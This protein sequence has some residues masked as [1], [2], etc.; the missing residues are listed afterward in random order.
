MHDN[1]NNQTPEEKNAQHEAQA[2]KEFAEIAASASTDGKSIADVEHLRMVEYIHSQLKH[3]QQIDDCHIQA[4]LTY[5]GKFIV[6]TFHRDIED[7]IEDTWK[8]LIE[9][10][11]FVLVENADDTTL[12]G[13]QCMGIE[14]GMF[15]DYGDDEE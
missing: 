2:E 4:I 1:K 6:C 3:F 8:L 5:Q 14:E 13:T 10:V 11:A 15:D 9:D 7:L 12:I